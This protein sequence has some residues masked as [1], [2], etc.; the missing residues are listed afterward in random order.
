MLV[1][2][3]VTVVDEVTLGAV[4]IPPPE[5]VPRFAD[6]VTPVFEVFRTVA[7]NCWL[8]AEL[9]LIEAGETVTLTTAGGLIVTVERA[10]LVVSA[11]LVAVMVAVVAEVTPPAVNIPLLEIVPPVA[12]HVTAVLEVLLTEAVNCWVPPEIRAEEVGETAMLTTAAALTVTVA[13]E[14][15]VGLATLVAVTVAVVVLVTLGAVNSPVLEIVPALALHVTDVFEELLTVAEN[16]CLPAEATLALPG[17]IPTETLGVPPEFA[18]RTITYTVT[19]PR[20]EL[21]SVMP[22]RKL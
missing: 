17:E 6:Q 13:C 2:M 21:G 9:R 1:A 19:S 12:L 11:T 18:A 15:L 22:T 7:A 3:I 4:N 5:I 10:D 20:S 8:P 14:R 16:C